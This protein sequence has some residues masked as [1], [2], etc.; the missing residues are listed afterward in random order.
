MQQTGLMYIVTAAPSVLASGF[1]GVHLGRARG[2]E[3]MITCTPYLRVIS[4]E[5]AHH[6]D[7]CCAVF[8]REPLGGWNVLRYIPSARDP[9]QFEAAGVFLYAG[10]CSAGGCCGTCRHEPRRLECLEERHSNR[11]GSCRQVPQTHHADLF[12]VGALSPSLLTQ[13]LH[14]AGVYFY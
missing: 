5:P 6:A 13:L 11:P 7:L 4:L 9:T 2:T 8:R 3:E 14:L 1:A 10:L 12:S